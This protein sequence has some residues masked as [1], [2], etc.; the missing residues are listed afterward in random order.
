VSPKLPALTGF[1]I[2]IKIL[3]CGS[4]ADAQE[5]VWLGATGDWN[6][7]SNWSPVIQPSDTAIFDS[8][9]NVRSITFS[10]ATTSIG[11]MRFNSAGSN[12]VFTVGSV[13]ASQTLSIG[14]M[15]IT[16]SSAS[17]TF[18]VSSYL[19]TFPK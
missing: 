2:L 10:G 14:A 7:A 16:G 12:Y 13:S 19:L 18:N 3:L 5:A 15:G 11:T 9:S 1:V 6:R 8:S 17:P 4:V